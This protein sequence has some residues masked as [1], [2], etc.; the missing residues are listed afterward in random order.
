ELCIGGLG[1]SRGYRDRPA[2]TADRFIP[3]PFGAEPG[4][5]LFRTGDIVRWRPDGQLVFLG[6]VDFQAKIRGFR[7]EPG[8]VESALLEH[9]GVRAAKVVA[10][11]G[12]EGDARLDAYLVLE[13]GATA[14]SG[15]YR[16]FLRDR[17]PGHMVPSSFTAMEALPLTPSGK[18]DLRALP[19]PGRSEV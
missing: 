17:L 14:A 9:P 12:V 10:R 15:A 2:Q 18:V 11:A 5:R 6:R 19:D 8:E 1:V 4:A 13:P 3:D 16:G 7:V